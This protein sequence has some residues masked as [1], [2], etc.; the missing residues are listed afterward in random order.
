MN[1]DDTDQK[2]VIGKA[3]SHCGGTETRRRGGTWD[4]EIHLGFSPQWKFIWDFH[5]K[6]R[7]GRK[8]R[9]GGVGKSPTSP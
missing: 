4:R 9:T 5:R 6:G 7:K 8:E 1:T 2:S 3:K